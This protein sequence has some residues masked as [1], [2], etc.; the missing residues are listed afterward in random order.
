MSVTTSFKKTARAQMD[1]QRQRDALALRLHDSVLQSLAA[2]RMHLKI[3]QD[4][5]FDD[6]QRAAEY[7][8]YVDALVCGEQEDLRAFVAELIKGSTLRAG[9][10]KASPLALLSKLAK[11]LEKQWKA[12]ID[13]VIESGVASLPEPIIESVLF[14][15]QEG[16]SNA[17]RHGK[18]SLIRVRLHCGRTSLKLIVADNGAGFPRQVSLGGVVP[19]AALPVMLKSRVAALGGVLVVHSGT[20]GV[21]LEIWLPL[22]PIVSK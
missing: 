5:L 14:I 8:G 10:Q 16:V 9:A 2:V 17:V 21:R 6:P 3:A 11:R 15:L 13:L 20:S 1:L 12:R 22:A 7:L 4:L 19:I 18:A